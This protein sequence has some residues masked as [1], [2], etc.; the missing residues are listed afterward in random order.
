MARIKSTVFTGDGVSRRS[1]RKPFEKSWLSAT[2]GEGYRRR[3]LVAIA[4]AIALH[5]ILAALIPPFSKA[6]PDGKEVIEHVT[7]A[8]VVKPTPTPT[9]KPTPT[10]IA[11]PRVVARENEGKQAVK[12]VIKRAGLDMVKP[13]KTIHTK[14]IWDYVPTK[15]GQGA[16][17]GVK[18]G[19]GSLG[20]GGQGTGTGNA[21][22]GAGAGACGAVDIGATGLATFNPNTGMYERNNVYAIVHFADGTAQRVNLDWTWR[23][24]TEEQ[25]PFKHVDLPLFF[26]FPPASQRAA[27]PPL[28]QYIMHNSNAQGHTLLNDQCPNIPAAPSPEPTQR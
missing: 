25:D 11:T 4:C 10:P 15:A 7:I 26:Q 19:A 9:P 17:A 13:P 16:G 18:E 21:G 28:V 22:N 24:Q 8:K 2:F 5:E 27:E 14:P 3:I 1:S 6:P 12:M 23:Y 20:T